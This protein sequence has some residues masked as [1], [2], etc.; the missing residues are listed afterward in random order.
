MA[1]MYSR[2]KGKHGSKKPP[3]KMAPRWVKYK[4][5]EVE[6]LVE[7]LAKERKTSALIGTILRDQYGIPDV[8]MVAGKTVSRIMKDRKLYPDMPEDMIS[9]LKKVVNLREHL[10][11]NKADQLSKKGL[12]NLESKIRRLGKYY[13]REGML[14]KDWRYDP[15][16]ARLLIQK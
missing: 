16:K 14:P 1:R 11:R 2:K 10:E 5:G 6:G 15:A 7:N 4:K 12:L 9:L 8:K 13:S 3:I